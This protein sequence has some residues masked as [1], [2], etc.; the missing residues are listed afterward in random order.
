MASGLNCKYYAYADD[1]KL[2]LQYPKGTV[3]GSVELQH[4]L[5][6]V[7]RKSLSW[8]LTLNHE[9]CVV[10][11]FGSDIVGDGGS[12]YVLNGVELKLVKTHR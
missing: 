1:F 9:K 8:G 10:M 7:N 6:V 3:G 11:R 4:D 2:Y 5:E 12:G